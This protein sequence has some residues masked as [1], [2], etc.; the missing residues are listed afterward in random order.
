MTKPLFWLLF[1]A[2][3]LLLVMQQGGVL[4]AAEPVREPQRLKQQLHPERIVL[5]PETRPVSAAPSCVEIGNFTSQTAAAFEARLSR[6]T[7]PALPQKRAMQEQSTHMVYLPP[8]DGQAGASRQLAQLRALGF[9]DVFVMQ[10]PAA[11]RWGIS[12]GLFKSEESA[13]SRLEAARRAG[14]SGARVE[15]FAKTFPRAAYQLRGLDAVARVELEVI[16]SDFAGVE[17]RA[18]S[19]D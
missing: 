3:I 16:R 12:L 10:E 5:A 19:A 7:L 17:S 1:L 6:L 9:K 11:R 15:A 4:G 18:C 8:Q 14:I 13:K 2:N